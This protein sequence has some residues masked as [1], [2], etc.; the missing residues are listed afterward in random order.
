VT[1]KDYAGAEADQKPLS[2][3]SVVIKNRQFSNG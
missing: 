2:G 1:L 3:F